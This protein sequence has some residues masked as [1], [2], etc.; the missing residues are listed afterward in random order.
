M[1]TSENGPGGASVEP[2]GLG[3]P[4]ERVNSGP[5]ESLL[6]FPEFGRLSHFHLCLGLLTMLFR[7]FLTAAQSCAELRWTSQQRM[8]H[9]HKICV[10]RFDA[11][12]RVG[13]FLLL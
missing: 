10:M 2:K 9:V 13:H 6:D 7:L 4:V 3:L 8:T 5:A 12:H 1:I 11:H